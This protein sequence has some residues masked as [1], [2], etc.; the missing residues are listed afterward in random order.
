MFAACYTPSFFIINL[1]HFIKI[2]AIIFTRYDSWNRC[3]CYKTLCFWSITHFCMCVC[4]C[5]RIR[6]IPKLFTSSWPTH[7]HT[8]I[9]NSTP[10]K[11][12]NKRKSKRKAKE[13]GVRAQARV[14]AKNA[15][16]SFSPSIVWNSI[17]DPFHVPTSINAWCEKKAATAAA[18]V[19]AT[20]VV[21]CYCGGK[22]WWWL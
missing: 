13:D 3:H 16:R 15:A 14:E 1:K 18:A 17:D 4:V 20:T 5:A 11:Y 6:N 19:S 8:M 9:K 21:G 2:C 22:W 12:G 7:T 10:I